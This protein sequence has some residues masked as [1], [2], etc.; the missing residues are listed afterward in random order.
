MYTKGCA[1]VPG[2]ASLQAV[3]VGDMS[4]VGDREAIGG[5]VEGHHVVRAGHQLVDVSAVSGDV[6][7]ADAG[8]GVVDT[9]HVHGDREPVHAKGCAAATSEGSLQARVVG[10]VSVVGDREAIG[11]E[12]VDH[13]VARSG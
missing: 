4:V 5:L 10:D 7:A 13:E 8:F 3:V 6:R 1:A 2:E 12:V 9:G 11:D